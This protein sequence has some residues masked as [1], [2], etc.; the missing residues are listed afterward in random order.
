MAGAQQPDRVE[1][2]LG[3]AGYYQRLIK[4]FASIAVLLNKMTSKKITYQCGKEQQE[5]FE[6]LKLAMT[7]APVLGKPNFQQ[8]WVLD[9][10]ASDVALG[11][12][13]G[14]EQADG[15]VH[16]VYFWSRQLGKP[17]KNYS[18]TDREC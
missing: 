4:D 11:V 15:E 5:A 3:L 7:T 9:V 18:V 2:F 1:G 10:N 16:L 13:L 8:D 12:V 14:Q 6:K 17:E